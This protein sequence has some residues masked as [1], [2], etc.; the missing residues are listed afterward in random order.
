MNKQKAGQKEKRDRW[1][2]R[3]NRKRKMDREID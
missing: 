3:A 2:E 1:T